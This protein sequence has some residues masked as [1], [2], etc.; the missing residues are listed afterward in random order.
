MQSSGLYTSGLF[1]CM[2]GF[3][4]MDAGNGVEVAW[5]N[6]FFCRHIKNIFLF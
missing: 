3:C 5:G 6:M 2:S 4:C 1:S